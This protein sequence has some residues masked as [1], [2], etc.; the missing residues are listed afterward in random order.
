ML[1]ILLDTTG[2]GKVLKRRTQVVYEEGSLTLAVPKEKPCPLIRKDIPVFLSLIG[3]LTV[4]SQLYMVPSISFQ[5]F[6]VQA[7]RIVV[8]S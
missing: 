2:R 7:F 4:A 6:F 3:H 5:T 1:L 8:D